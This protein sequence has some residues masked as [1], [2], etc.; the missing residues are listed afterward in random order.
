VLSYLSIN[1]MTSTVET[2]SKPKLSEK[3]G[4]THINDIIGRPQL[5]IKN[6]SLVDSGQ[7]E[8]RV[9][10]CPPYACI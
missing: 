2:F 3:T 7:P 6:N 5:Y 1:A 10:K 9:G 8:G 4:V